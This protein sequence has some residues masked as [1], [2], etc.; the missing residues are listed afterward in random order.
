M[1]H[2]LPKPNATSQNTF[3]EIFHRLALNNFQRNSSNRRFPPKNVYL[4]DKK[5]PPC[6]FSLKQKLILEQCV[7][8]T[9]HLFIVVT[10]NRYTKKRMR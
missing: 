8:N 2:N 5:P 1:S 10:H 9:R 4:E 3:R 6:H 7:H